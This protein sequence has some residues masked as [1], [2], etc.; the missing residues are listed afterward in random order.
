MRLSRKSSHYLAAGVLLLFFSLSILLVRSNIDEQRVLASKVQE[1]LLGKQLENQES[2]STTVNP[3]AELSAAPEKETEANAEKSS[4]PVVFRNFERSQTKDGELLWQIRGEEAILDKETGR[5][6]VKAGELS[7]N[8]E[9]FGRIEIEGDN[10]TI[11]SQAGQI[12]RA[13]SKG[14]VKIN[15]PDKGSL[16]SSEAIFDNADQNLRGDQP[17]KIRSDRFVI[18]GQSFRFQFKDQVLEVMGGVESVLEPKNSEG[19]Q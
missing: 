18:N 3:E 17:V 14:N 13:H 8:H 7:F 15:S 5:I 2:S 19:Q 16:E 10:T 12:L 4:I 11:N 1:P 9:E 6:E